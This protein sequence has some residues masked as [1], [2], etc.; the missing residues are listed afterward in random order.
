MLAASRADLSKAFCNYCGYPPMGP[1]RLRAHRVCMRCQMGTVLRAPPDAEPRFDEP[2]VIVDERL[3]VQAISH[4]AELLLMVND[5]D[6]FGV[7]LQEFLVSTNG[8][9]DGL[10][11]ALM[12]EQAIAGHPTPGSLELR[13]AR[14]AAICH[15]GR[16]VGCGPPPAALLILGVPKPDIQR[17]S[18]GLRP[19]A[20]KRR[21]AVHAAGGG[22]G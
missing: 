22:A 21:L 3:I 18:N 15:V 8:D 1:W 12:A 17:S 10:T 19:G 4:R 13:T 6:G 7:P 5:P 11:L 16:V 20:S 14:D 2:F 9:A